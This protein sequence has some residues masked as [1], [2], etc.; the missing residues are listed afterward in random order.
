MPAKAASHGAPARRYLNEKVTGVLLEGMKRLAAEQYVRCPCLKNMNLTIDADPKILYVFWE[1][2]CCKGV[3]KWSEIRELRSHTHSEGVVGYL[4][5]FSIPGNAFFMSY[6]YIGRI[7]DR[8]ANRKCNSG[9]V[10]FI[11]QL[12]ISTDSLAWILGCFILLV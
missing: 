8:P 10:S 7:M 2:F 6:T 1:S 5:G 9:I 4:V 3:K 11:A 12:P